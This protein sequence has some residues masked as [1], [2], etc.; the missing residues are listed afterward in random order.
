M[1]FATCCYQDEMDL[2]TL[3][4]MLGYS[5][6]HS[7]TIYVHLAELGLRHYNSPMKGMVIGP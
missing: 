2:L 3:S 1:R 4:K 7:T 6:I 5:N